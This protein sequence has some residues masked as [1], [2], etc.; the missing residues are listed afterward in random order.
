[1]TRIAICDDEEWVREKLVQILSEYSRE[2]RREFEIL[3]YPNANV[4]L[5]E[6]P[7]DLDLLL[8]DIAMNGLD[9]IDAAGEVRKIDQTVSII[10][11]TS[12]VNRAIDGYRVHAYGFIKKPIDREELRYHLTGVLAQIDTRKSLGSYISIQLPK[13]S[14]RL[15]V[16]DIVYAEVKDHK[17]SIHIGA[18]T[19]DFWLS[20]NDLENQLNQ[21]GFFRPHSA[22]LVNYRFIS[23]VD[24]SEL[25]LSN[26]ER[27]PISQHRRKKF[28][29]QMSQYV[30]EMG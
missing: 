11:I 9:G 15:P 14:Q 22:F 7:K 18:E 4:L 27:I 2:K 29:E 3:Q 1:M 12:M 19:R 23:R 25:V 17:I 5:R 20:M 21:Y 28:L 6:Y 8:L 26:G 13:G 30:R 16:Y 24:S 10:F